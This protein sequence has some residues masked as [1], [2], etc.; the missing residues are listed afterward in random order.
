ML[1]SNDQFKNKTYLVYGY[2]K[3]GSATYKYLKKNNKVFIFD[4]N[5]NFISIKKLKLINFDF[6]VLS[7][8]ID[9][10]KCKLKNFLKLYKK[11]NN[12]RS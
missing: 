7:P 8:G 6:I 4:D 3:T 1:K 9:I 10:K 5:K 2:G 12:H 11:K